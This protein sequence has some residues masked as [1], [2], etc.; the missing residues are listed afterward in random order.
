MDR[1]YKRINKK[2]WNRRTEVHIKSMFYDNDS[3][4]EGRSSLNSIELD[5]MGQISGKKVLHLQCH[6]GQDSIS[7]A[8]MGADV[9]GVDLSDVAIKQARSMAEKLGLNTRFIESD[10]LELDQRLTGMFD[11]ILSTYGTICWLP[12]LKK[13]A[14]IVNQ[15]LTPGG[16]LILVEFHPALWMFDDLFSKIEYSYFNVEDIVENEAGTYTDGGK[17]MANESIS[18]NH[19][20]SEVIGSLLSVGLTITRFAEYDYSPYD[21]FNN[22]V[23]SERGY[24]IKGLEGKLPMLYA[25]EATK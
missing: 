14:E 5:L 7:M 6:F 1:D 8:R 10:V 4:L 21:C 12:D 17:G 15:Y 20:F 13:W 16:R 9:T 19:P 11:M 25:L 3:F 22:T 24:Q 23:R 18:W 2:Q